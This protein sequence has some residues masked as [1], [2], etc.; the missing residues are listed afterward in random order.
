MK[1]KVTKKER[2]KEG[3]EMKFISPLIIMTLKW[4]MNL[5]EK[6]KGKNWYSPIKW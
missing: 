1:V 4:K 6:K 3:N 5:E 2:K